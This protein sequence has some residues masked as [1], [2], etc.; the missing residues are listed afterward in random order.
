MGQVRPLQLSWSLGMKRDVSRENMPQGSAWNLVD[1]FPDA[2][3]APL[4]KRGGWSYESANIAATTATAAYVIAGMYAPFSAAAKNLAVDEDGRLYSIASNGTV[5]DIGAAV[6]PK[7]PLSFHR[8]LAVIT[9]SNGTTAPKSY[10]G[11][12]LQDLAGSPPAGQFSSVYKDRT[13]LANSTAQPNRVY[14]SGAGDPTSWDTTNGYI[15]ADFPVT[16]IASLRNALIV[17]SAQQV[18]RIIGS[19]PPPGTDMARQSLYQPGCVDARSI[20]IAD[21]TCFFANPTGLYQTDGAAIVDVTDKG[22]MKRY[23]L[24]LFSAYASTWTI[25]CGRLRNWIIVS[26]MD[27]S[28]F[29]D[30][31]AVHVYDRTWVRLSNIKAVMQW[32]SVSAAPETYFGYR[33]GAYVGELTSI[34]SPAAGVKAD[35]DGTSVT[36]VLETPWFP[37]GPSKSPIRDIYVAYDLRDAASDNPTLTLSYV[38]SP[39]NTSYTAVSDFSG[40]A[41]TLAETSEFTR[42][43][44]N[45]R[46][47]GFGVALKLAQSNASSDT[48]LYRLETDSHKREATRVA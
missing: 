16:G 42:V 21:D 4:V 43:R 12:T 32:S 40:S 11:T 34:L 45:L 41:Y 48:R 1:Y 29:K 8:N 44:R 23:W 28:T 39:E 35:A 30:A 17:F 10:D 2:L 5:T 46:K 25:S 38:L 15:D 36:P 20:C 26:V 3:G 31:F 14:F 33:G 13:V 22:E 27:G 6:T 37:I 18:E 7:A 19:T 24:E 9:A 47:A